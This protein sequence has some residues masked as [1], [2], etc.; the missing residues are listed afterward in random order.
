MTNQMNVIYLDKFDFLTTLGRKAS[1]L[2]SSI[3]AQ[4]KRRAAHREL[5]Q[6]D[7]RMLADIGIERYDLQNGKLELFRK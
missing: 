6:L 2:I 4:A 7:D 3:V 1:A 5:M